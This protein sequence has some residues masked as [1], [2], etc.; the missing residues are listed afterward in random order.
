MCFNSLIPYIDEMLF[1]PLDINNMCIPLNALLWIT[2]S[3]GGKP[4]SVPAAGESLLI[5]VEGPS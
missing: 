3:R 2:I 5:L 4:L 1:S